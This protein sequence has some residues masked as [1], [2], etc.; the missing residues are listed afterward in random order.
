MVNKLS[1]C[2]EGGNEAQRGQEPSLRGHRLIIVSRL[3]LA[4]PSDFRLYCTN[5]SLCLERDCDISYGTK[6][7]SNKSLRTFIH[8]TNIY[9][10]TICQDLGV[11]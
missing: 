6:V 1:C 4:Y 5:S 10:P 8:L 3:P 2:A 9:I 11:G 7:I